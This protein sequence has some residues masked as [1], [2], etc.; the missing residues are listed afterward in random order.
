LDLDAEDDRAEREAEAP[1]PLPTPMPSGNALG[2][3][4]AAEAEPWKEEGAE[5]DKEEEEEEHVGEASRLFEDDEQQQQQQE[6]ERHAGGGDDDG[7]NADASCAEPGAAEDWG[8]GFEPPA[9][10]EPSPIR[11][12]AMPAP[13]SPIGPACAVHAVPGLAV[14]RCACRVSASEAERFNALLAEAEAARGDD[15]ATLS[16][17]LDALAICDSDT[18]LQLHCRALARRLGLATH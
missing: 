17:L 7:G 4:E 9:P 11:Q 5:E 1:L 2:K 15:A 8:P 16:A 12:P 13:A 3:A 6:Q 14:L 10:C 18:A